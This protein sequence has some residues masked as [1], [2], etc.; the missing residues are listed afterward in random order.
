MRLPEGH[1]ILCDACYMTPVSRIGDVCD[2]CRVDEARERRE[3][4]IDNIA[5]SINNEDEP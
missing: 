4:E 5:K 2:F 1:E 3:N